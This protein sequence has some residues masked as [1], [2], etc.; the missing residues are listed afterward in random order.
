MKYYLMC[1]QK[2]TSVASYHMT[3][4]T[5]KYIKR[6]KQLKQKQTST[7]NTKKSV[8]SVRLM[9]CEQSVM[10]KIYG[11]ICFSL[12]S[13]GRL[14]HAVGQGSKTALSTVVG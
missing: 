8:K 3:S 9:K 13:V 7:G 12:E 5:K 10:E 4:K 2:L 6:K 11:K 14:F 1:A